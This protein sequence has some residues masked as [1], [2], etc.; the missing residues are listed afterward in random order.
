MTE[1]TPGF[2]LEWLTNITDAHRSGVAY[3]SDS[4]TT[5]K[6]ILFVL[7]EYNSIIVV[8][9]EQTTQVKQRKR[10]SEP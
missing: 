4:L 8:S 10:M 1:K 5:M 7:D 3:S 9:K 6:N 2:Y